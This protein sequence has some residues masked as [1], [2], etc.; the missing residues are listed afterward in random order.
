MSGKSEQVRHT[1][2]SPGACS[3]SGHWELTGHSQ[4]AGESALGGAPAA[5]SPPT[6]AGPLRLCPANSKPVAMHTRTKESTDKDNFF[7]GGGVCLPARLPCPI[8]ALARPAPVFTLLTFALVIPSPGCPSA[9]CGPQVQ[10]SAP[11][12]ASPDTLK[13]SPKA[14]AGSYTN[15]HGPRG[16]FRPKRHQITKAHGMTQGDQ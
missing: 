13:P 2:C 9:D 4:Q 3:S 8:S 6:C 12:E 11:L 15:L 16:Y 1:V 7:L 14:L 10:T 5:L